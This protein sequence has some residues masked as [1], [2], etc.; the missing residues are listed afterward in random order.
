MQKYVSFLKN[1]QG[2]RKHK[3]G[4]SKQK[5]NCQCLK[6]A[7]AL[8]QASG[9]F[10]YL[11]VRRGCPPWMESF[12]LLRLGIGVRVDTDTIRIFRVA[13]GHGATGAILSGSDAVGIWVLSAR[14]GRGRHAGHV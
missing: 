2:K 5:G 7:P 13:D 10:A 14:L 1:M 9:P 6:K 8:S 11:F 3:G 12:R 4:N